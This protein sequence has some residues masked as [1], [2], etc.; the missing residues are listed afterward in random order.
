MPGVSAP[1][2]SLKDKGCWRF[3]PVGVGSDVTANMWTVDGAN[4]TTSGRTG[5]FWCT[6]ASSDR[7]FKI[8]AQQLRASSS[9]GAGGHR[10]TSSAGHRTSSRQRVSI[11]PQ[12]RVQRRNYFLEKAKQPRGT[13]PNDFGASIG[14][15]IIKDRLPSSARWSGTWR[16]GDRAGGLRPT[17][18]KR[19]DF[20]GRWIAVGSAAYPGESPDRRA[21]P[22]N[23]IPANRLSPGG[24]SMLALYRCRTSRRRP[25]AAQLG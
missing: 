14:W 6:P 12:R 23:R 21:V 7:G 25:Q 11:G 10:S 8:L 4:T 9:G 1:T 2:S 15:S 3:G 16:S 19:G 18:R 24:Q 13:E 22:G 20:S 17:E 5:R